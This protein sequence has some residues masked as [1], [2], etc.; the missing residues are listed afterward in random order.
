MWDLMCQGD[1][2][3]G[4]CF[5]VTLGRQVVEKAA[6]VFTPEGTAASV[7]RSEQTPNLYGE[8]AGSDTCI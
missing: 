3:E 7:L 8:Y 1:H 4:I 5:Y 6:S 2:C